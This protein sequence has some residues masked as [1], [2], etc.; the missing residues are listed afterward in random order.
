MAHKEFKVLFARASVGENAATLAGPFGDAFTRFGEHFPAVDV[1]GEKFQMRDMLRVGTVWKGTFG[2][3]RDDAPHV[4]QAGQ[5]E[6][7]IDL[8]EDE[9]LLEKCHFLYKEL[10]NTIAWQVNRSAGGFTRASDYLSRLLDQVVLLS[11][12]MNEDDLQRVLNGDLYEIDFAY[13][14][15][16]NLTGN[17]P[18][19]N[20]HAFNMMNRIDAA[21]AKFTLRAPRNGSLVGRWAKS[22][23]RQMVDTVGVEKIR[24]RLTEE[25]DPVELFMAPLKDTIRVELHG[26]YAIADMAYE[27]LSAAYD[28]NQE[29]LAPV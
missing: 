24:I 20:Q 11:T 4:V 7:E 17:A 18:I 8:E 3:L 22:M 10:D 2:K 6:R 13:A 21:H 5:K 14:R 1:G 23:V 9:F 29:T 15:P 28:R 27:E 25:S 12:I 26:R 19:W 16:H